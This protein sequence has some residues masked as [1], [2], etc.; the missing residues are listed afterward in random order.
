MKEDTGSIIINDKYYLYIAC[1]RPAYPSEGFVSPVSLYI[2]VM[3]GVV[4]L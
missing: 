3:S 4:G 2:V 1:I